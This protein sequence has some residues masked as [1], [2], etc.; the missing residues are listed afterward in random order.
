MFYKR[1]GHKGNFGNEYLQFEINREGRLRYLNSSCY[2][3][4]K[5]IKREV[6]LNDVVIE[7]IIKI[8]KSSNVEKYKDKR[9]PYPDK[10]GKQ[11]LEFSI[12]DDDY[13]YT[14]SKIGS[15]SEIENSKDPEG[16]NCFYCLIQ[17]IKCLIMSLISLNFKSKPV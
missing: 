1:V 12:D 5:E 16:L 2:K 9:W 6:Y 4:E 13:K 17:D 15:Y 11:T 3:S 10:N 14:T 8:I 7:E